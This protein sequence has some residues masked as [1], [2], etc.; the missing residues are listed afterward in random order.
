[1]A[2]HGATGPQ[3]P[4]GAQ[5]IQGPAGATG[6]QGPIGNTGPTGATGPQGATGLTGATGA[7]GPQGVAG[8]AGADSTVPGPAGPQGA[9]GATGPQGPQG[10]PGPVTFGLYSNAA[11]HA[12]GTTIVIPQT[13]HGLSASRRILVQAKDNASGNVEVPDI[14]V[15]AG[16]DVTLTFLASVAANSVLV[17]CIG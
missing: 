17:T 16:G 6:A 2:I 4:Q 15:S 10:V 3:G 11:T 5:G 14:N 7:Q 1:M 8:P 12:A 9:T 13:T